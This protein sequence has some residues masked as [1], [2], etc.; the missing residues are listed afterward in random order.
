M[1]H[2]RVIN[3]AFFIEKNSTTSKLDVFRV[4]SPK[5]IEKL[6]ARN[7]SQTAGLRAW[8]SAYFFDQINQGGEVIAVPLNEGVAT[9]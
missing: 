1:F 2:V 8:N 9:E 6:N 3:R 5:K 4:K 7:L